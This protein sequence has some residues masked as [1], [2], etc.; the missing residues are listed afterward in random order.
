MKRGDTFTHSHWLT[1]DHRQLRCVVTAV[2]LGIV[3]WRPVSG[4]GAMSFPIEQAA[5][6]VQ[7]M[8]LSHQAE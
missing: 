6:Y 1:I 5:R 7:P 2:R 4:G 3:Y 8:M